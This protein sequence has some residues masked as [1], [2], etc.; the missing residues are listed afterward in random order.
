MIPILHILEGKCYMDYRCI[1]NYLPMKIYAK[2]RMKRFIA[3]I[4]D[5]SFVRHNDLNF[6]GRIAMQYLV[7][8]GAY[9]K[10]DFFGRTLYIKAET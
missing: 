3:L 8:Q 9:H 1:E 6:V 7:N 10:Q 4:S 5:K 2:P